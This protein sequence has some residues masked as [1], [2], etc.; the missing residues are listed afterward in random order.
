MTNTDANDLL[1]Q[2]E[3]SRHYDPSPKLESIVAPVMFVNSADDFINPPELGL[4]EREVKRVK[5]AR[6]VLIPASERTRGHGTH[7][8]AALWKEHLVELL[9]LSRR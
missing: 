7:T 2:V 6:F 1:Y 8:W 3:A 5:R 4:A 9:A